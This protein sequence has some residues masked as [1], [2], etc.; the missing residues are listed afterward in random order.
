MVKSPVPLASASES[1]V[2]VP[3]SVVTLRLSVMPLPAVADSVLNVESPVLNVMEPPEFNES[4]PEIL[5]LLAAVIPLTVMLPSV[6]SPMVKP[7]AVMFCNSDPS[8]VQLPAVAPNPMVP[9]S[10]TNNVVAPAP[11]FRLPLMVTSF[12][13]IDN[14][15]PLVLS[16]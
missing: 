11:E 16:V 2:A 14:A 6:L 8:K 1:K 7:V 4:V 3:A 15:P 12:A 5:L 13:V 10:E 9:L